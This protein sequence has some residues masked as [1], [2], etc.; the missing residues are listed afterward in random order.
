MRADKPF[1]YLLTARAEQARDDLVT[2]RSDLLQ[3]VWGPERPAR[4]GSL[5]HPGCTWNEARNILYDAVRAGSAHY[6]FL[7]FLDED[8]GAPPPRAPSL[9]RV[10]PIA[11]AL[12]PTRAL[13]RGA[14][15]AGRLQAS[16]TLRPAAPDGGGSG[17]EE[18]PW[19]ELERLLLLWQPAARP[20][21]RP[22]ARPR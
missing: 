13:A 3:L 20:P 6:T 10:R 1:V 2:P 21:A 12:A 15:D 19:R 5:W 8:V 7:I 17:V 4:P 18:D 22:P 9:A 14:A 16:L 11:R